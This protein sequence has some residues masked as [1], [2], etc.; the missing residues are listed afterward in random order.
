MVTGCWVF[1]RL[2]IALQIILL[3]LTDIMKDVLGFARSLTPRYRSSTKSVIE[4][5]EHVDQMWICFAEV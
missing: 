3:Q 1:Y 2:L 4:N 5:T